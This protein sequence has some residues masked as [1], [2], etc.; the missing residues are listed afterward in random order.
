M[1]STLLA[2]SGLPEYSVKRTTEK[3]VIDGILDESD[4]ER[5][6]SVGDF[7]FPWW[8]SGEKEQTEVKILWDDTFLYISYKVDDKHIWAEHYDTNAT[9]YKD[10]CVELFWNPDPR[11]EKYNMFEINAIGNLLSVYTG[12]GVSIHERISRIIPPHIAQTIQGT[13]NN[14]DDIDTGWILEVAVRFSDYPELSVKSAPEPGDMWRIGL[15]RLGGKTNPQYSQWSSA[16]GEEP[17]F[18]TPKFFGKIFFSNEN[19]R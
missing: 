2:A 8:E 12:S 15:N 19:V 1:F 13:V 9:T 17:A 5:A 4:W 6:E 7:I 18:H 3:I 14:D 10:D 11:Q 16:G